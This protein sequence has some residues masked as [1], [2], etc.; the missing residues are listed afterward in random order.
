MAGIGKGMTDWANMRNKNLS[1]TELT[2]GWTFRKTATFLRICFDLVKEIFLLFYLFG[3][4][5]FLCG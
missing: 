1:A 4:P 3:G 2:E 5:G